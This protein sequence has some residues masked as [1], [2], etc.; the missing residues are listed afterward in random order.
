[1]LFVYVEV[2]LPSQPIWVMLSALVYLTT[3]FQG[4]ISP[5]SGKPVLVRILSPETDNIPSWISGREKMTVEIFHDQYSRQNV[6]GD[7]TH[8]LLDSSRTRIRLS[9]HSRLKG[10]GYNT[11]DNRYNVLQTTLFIPTL[12]TTTRFLILTIWLSWNLRLR[13]KKTKK[14]KKKINK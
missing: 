8:D 2:L 5:L 14:K 9:H 12:D 6:T 13:K 7:R 10:F 4:M 1:M 11:I 3:L